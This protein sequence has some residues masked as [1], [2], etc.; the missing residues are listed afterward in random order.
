VNLNGLKIENKSFRTSNET[1]NLSKSNISNYCSRYELRWLEPE[2]E[3]L[4]KRINRSESLNNY[5]FSHAPT[6]IRTSNN[7]YK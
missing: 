4:H 1:L 3:K 2:T 6:S 7:F 5:N